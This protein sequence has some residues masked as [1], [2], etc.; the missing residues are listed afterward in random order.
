MLFESPPADAP[1]RDAMLKRRLNELPPHP[2][3]AKNDLPAELDAIVVKMLAVRPDDRFQTAA[4]LRAALDEIRLGPEAASALTT[5][6]ATV[7]PRPSLDPSKAPTLEAP[8]ATSLPA[9]M[10]PWMRT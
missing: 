5:S 2:S 6:G 3:R 10:P 9:W 8:V 1:T 4:E 7:M